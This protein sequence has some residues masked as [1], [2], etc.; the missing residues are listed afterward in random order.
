MSALPE[1]ATMKSGEAA[2]PRSKLAFSSGVVPRWPVG[3]MIVTAF[4]ARSLA[5]QARVQEFAQGVAHDVEGQHGEYDGQPREGR[6]PRTA[7]D[8]LPALAED[9]AP[10]RGGRRDAEA[11][12]GQAR[13][14]ADGRGDVE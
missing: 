13:L 5:A 14:R 7:L 11:Q 12:E 2:Q 9:V 10:A 3:V 8:V 1:A 4:T 6:D